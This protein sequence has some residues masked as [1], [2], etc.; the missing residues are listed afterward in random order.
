MADIDPENTASIRIAEK[1]GFEMENVLKD[2][3][4]TA[5]KGLRDLAVYQL[6]R[7]KPYVAE[8]KRLFLQELNIEKHLSEIHAWHSL[9][10][11]L[12][13]S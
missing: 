12:K 9:P 7:P 8:T 3:Y 10:D 2:A 6:L 11:G 5:S 1:N 4:T 13:F